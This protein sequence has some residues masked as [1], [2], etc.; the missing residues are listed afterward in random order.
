M[1]RL[2]ADVQVGKKN[3]VFG[4]ALFLLFGVVIGIP[5]TINMFGGSVL[6]DEQYQ[7]WKVVHGY[8]VFLAFINYFFGLVVD[9][10]KLTAQQ[11]QISSW[12]FLLAGLFGAIAR[13]TL[14]LFSALSTYGLYVSLVESACFIVGT[15][16]FV[17]GQLRASE[18]PAR[19]PRPT[20][21]R[22]RGQGQTR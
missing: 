15:S 10:L 1:D 17:V 12:S 18:P 3:V 21:L 11:K 7:A 13:M 14:V 22:L 16:I 9:R 5:L 8:A 2:L 4:I 20:D 6:T 19:I